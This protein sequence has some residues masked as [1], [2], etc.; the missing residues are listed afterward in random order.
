M[1]DELVDI[2]KN[3]GKLF[4]KVGELGE[5]IAENG[6]IL[7]RIEKM[8]ERLPCVDHHDR[9]GVVEK[10]ISAVEV[11]WKVVLGGC[12]LVGIFLGAVF[13]IGRILGKF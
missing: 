11:T 9:L 1:S 13:Y 8:I 2:K 6:V 7:P 12:S 3:V 4:D 10:G 5:R